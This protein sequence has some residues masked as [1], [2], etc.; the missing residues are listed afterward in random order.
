MF[1]GPDYDGGHFDTRP[2]VRNCITCHTDQQRIGVTSAASVNYVFPPNPPG[3]N[4][5]LT[6]RILDGEVI[7][8]MPIMVH[9]IHMGNR[10]AKQGYDTDGQTFNVCHPQDIQL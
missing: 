4:R 1:S 7:F 6:P 5:R 8:D 2:D 9:K 10:L 3:T